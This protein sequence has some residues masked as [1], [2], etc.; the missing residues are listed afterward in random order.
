[1][2]LSLGS[3]TAF[4]Q[5]GEGVTQEVATEVAVAQD[6]FTAIEAS[7]LPE[8]VS[9]ALATDHPSATINKAA[10][11]KEEQYK[12]EVALEDGTEATLY[13]DKEGNWIELE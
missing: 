7:E 5:E 10:V 8:A 4:A 2:V 1:A 13:A 6:D 9:T 3:L 12:L 11:N